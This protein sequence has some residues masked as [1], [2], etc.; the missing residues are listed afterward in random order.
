MNVGVVVEIDA[1]AERL[2]DGRSARRLVSLELADVWADPDEVAWK[3]EK[4]KIGHIRA[5]QIFGYGRPK[6]HEA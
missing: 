5:A 2:V 1:A 4:H 6:R 3:M